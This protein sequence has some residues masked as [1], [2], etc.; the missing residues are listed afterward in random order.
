M[1]VECKNSEL[2]KPRQKPNQTEPNV[3]QSRFVHV[4][5]VIYF[6]QTCLHFDHYAHLYLHSAHIA[7]YQMRKK[8]NDYP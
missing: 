3:R 2:G 5:P 6:E 4:R 7:L 1:L 8:R